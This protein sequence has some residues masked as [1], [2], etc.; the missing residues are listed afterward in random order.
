MF[1]ILK[2]GVGGRVKRLFN[3]AQ[4]P[5]LE[6]KQEI[7]EAI[8]ESI[9]ERVVDP[10]NPTKEEFFN[11]IVDL[12]F[13]MYPG[14]DRISR[15]KQRRFTNCIVSRWADQWVD[16]LVEVTTEEQGPWE[17]LAMQARGCQGMTESNTTSDIR[18]APEIPRDE[19]TVDAEPDELGPEDLPPPPG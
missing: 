13:K 19:E 7:E 17:R 6:S 1:D 18:L 12:A 2:Y 10:E 8:G 9:D 4:Q 15:L 5:R 16:G 3:Y 11:V 14:D